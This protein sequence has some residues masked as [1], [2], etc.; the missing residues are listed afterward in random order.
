MPASRIAM[1][2]TTRRRR[3]RG[4]MPAQYVVA[5]EDPADS[6][7]PR[8]NRRRLTSR[9]SRGSRL[10][11]S[12]W[13]EL[14]LLG[15]G[16]DRHEIGV[17]QRLLMSKLEANL[18]PPGGPAQADADVGLLLQTRL[19]FIRL[20]FGGPMTNYT[21]FGGWYGFAF[22]VI[23]LAALTAGIVSSG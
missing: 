14:T 4:M 5:D 9:D 15:V 16:R 13:R 11:H 1:P 2:A 6:F 8:G 19:E 17:L 20:Q 22:T 23:S 10:D 3:I 12:R 7:S 21:R 18:A